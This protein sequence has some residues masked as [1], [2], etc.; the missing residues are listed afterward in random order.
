VLSNAERAIVFTE[1]IKSANIAARN[2]RNLNIAAEAYTSRLKHDVRKELLSNFRSG[3]TTVLAAPRVLDEGIDVPEADV[4]V[5]VAASQSRRQMVQRM[6]RI[7]RPKDD[8]RRATFIILYVQNT[9]EDP[10]RGAHGAF[11][12][13]M[14][15]NADEIRCFSKNVNKQDLLDWYFDY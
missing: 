3:N 8:N 5:I 1:T 6:G 11:L 2:L 14:V 4:G 7:I 13:E 15:D 9:S 12:N 10:K